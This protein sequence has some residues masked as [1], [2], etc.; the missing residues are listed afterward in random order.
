M[1]QNNPPIILYHGSSRKIEQ[2]LTMH[3]GRNPDNNLDGNQFGIYATPDWATA[4]VY[5]M[6]ARRT[7]L[8]R[9]KVLDIGY[10]TE[11]IRVVFR[12]CCWDRKAGYIYTIS[13]D[14]F[15]WHNDFEYC[16]HQN[17]PIIES[18]EI[19]P[20][21]ID[22]MV[23]SG[24]LVITQDNLPNSK[25]IRAFYSFIDKCIHGIAAISH[26][27]YVIRYNR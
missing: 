7:T 24:K 5:T 9:P 15:S 13:A 16:S 20:A 17:V 4:V 26:C 27:Y 10:S 6:G 19:V 25:L 2:M 21:E 22:K 11:S 23:E 14:S 18:Q 1:N 12:N 8:F 3:R